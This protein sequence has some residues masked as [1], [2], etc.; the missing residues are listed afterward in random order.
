MK[1]IVLL[2]SLS[3]TSLSWAD[4][5]AYSQLDEFKV[6][7]ESGQIVYEAQSASI[8]QT[9]L[10]KDIAA[11]QSNFNTLTVVD[12]S[13][14]IILDQEFAENFSM[15]NK[16][17]SS[18]ANGQ[19]RVFNHKGEK[20]VQ[21]SWVQAQAISNTMF[22]YREDRA[23]S[24][25]V[26]L[27]DQGKEIFSVWNN[28]KAKIS[29]NF[30]FAED[31]YGTLILFDQTGKRLQYI[32]NFKKYDLSDSYAAIT[33]NYD[34]TQIFNTKGEVVLSGYG[35]TITN[36]LNELISYDQN[37]Q[38]FIINSK[39]EKI[40]WSSMK[41]QVSLLDSGFVYKDNT[42]YVRFMN[43]SGMN[44]YSTLSPKTYFLTSNLLGYQ[45]SEQN[46]TIFN[47]ENSK[48]FEEFNPSLSQVIVSSEMFALQSKTSN[49][50][51]VYDA[52]GTLLVDELNVQNVWIST[53]NPNLNWNNF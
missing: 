4:F 7:N 11:I 45:T 6:L 35:I 16:F 51:R 30:V 5:T 14:T 28:L 15:T 41:G 13:G 12:K 40:F 27:D 50:L 39:K 53:T 3:L 48:I 32:N 19:F 43:Q 24:L 2:A 47:F 1:F 34:F 29:D 46:I 44:S 52:L 22:A 38:T 42:G 18:L 21:E 31:I 49:G 23:G 26:V 25:L 10:R 17:I 36:L 9:D 8:K 37:G 20:L 33:D